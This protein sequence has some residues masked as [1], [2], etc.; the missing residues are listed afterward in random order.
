MALCWYRAVVRQPPNRGDDVVV[1]VTVSLDDDGFFLYSE[2]LG[3]SGLYL[4]TDLHLGNRFR[5]LCTVFKHFRATKYT[6]S[7]REHTE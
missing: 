2:T 7:T 1:V 3:L 4:S 5:A 6:F